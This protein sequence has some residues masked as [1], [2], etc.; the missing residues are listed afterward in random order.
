VTDTYFFRL[1]L[2]DG[3][4]GAFFKECA[5]LSSEQ[6][7]GSS[8]A[9][10]FPGQQRW[11]NLTLR[12]GVDANAALWTWRRLVI[13]GRIDEARADGTIE[14]V[15]ADGAPVVT[16]AFTRGWPCKYSAPGMNAGG[17][18]ILVEELE[19]AHEGVTR[20]VA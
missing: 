2:G 20:R 3:G 15:D 16:Y 5:G 13:D 4:A 11:S 17:D 19:I 12:R 1:T 9:A 10:R 14:V 8:L 18:E 6:A 7:E